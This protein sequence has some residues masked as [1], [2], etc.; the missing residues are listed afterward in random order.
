MY[1]HIDL[2][3]THCHLYSLDR[4]PTEEIVAHAANCRVTRMISIGAGSGI[5]SASLSV[6]LADRF[7]AVFA[8]VGI[9]PHD[10]KTHIT[11]DE[12]ATLAHH[13]KVVAVGETGLD[14][15]R[16]WAPPDRQRA[17][18]EHTIEF[19]K[20]QR[21]PLIIHCRDAEQETLETLTRLNARDVGGVF[22]CYAGDVELAKRLVDLN[23][24]VS[25]TGTLTFKRADALRETARA[26][27]LEQIMLETDAPYMAPEPF[28]GQSS[29]PAHV[30]QIARKLAEVKGVPLEEI[31][32]VT[33]ANAERLFGL[34]PLAHRD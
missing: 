7:P 25:I 18:F 23:F 17:L 2:I 9:H 14:F 1:E 6:G 8:S 30:F 21:K 13:P 3:D 20:Q 29:E 19:A 32:R 28:R 16:D 22:H 11:L 33:S 31:A 15:F 10:A 12:I 5:E 4:A 34:R 26:I 27:P 24:L